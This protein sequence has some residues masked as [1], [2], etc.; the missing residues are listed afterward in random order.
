M[1]TQN[2]I[3]KN[4]VN[5]ANLDDRV[6]TASAQDANSIKG[7]LEFLIYKYTKAFG[8]NSHSENDGHATGCGKSFYAGLTWKGCARIASLEDMV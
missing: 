8:S 7:E 1:E 6:K 5:I 2:G 4:H 3:P